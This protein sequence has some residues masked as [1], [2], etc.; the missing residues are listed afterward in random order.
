VGKLMALQFFVEHQL[1]TMP[2]LECFW[3]GEKMF[4]IPSRRQG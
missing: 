3:L 1:A 4:R 2:R